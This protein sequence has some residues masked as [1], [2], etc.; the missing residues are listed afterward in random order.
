MSNSEQ[1]AAR[2]DALD[3]HD[4]IVQGLA[5]AKLRLELG[6]T[7]AGMAALER[8]LDAARELV[9]DLVDERDAGT[10]SHAGELRRVRAAKLA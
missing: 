4:D 7:E 1:R 10:D 6:D 3:R 5:L 8:T 9:I 2:Q